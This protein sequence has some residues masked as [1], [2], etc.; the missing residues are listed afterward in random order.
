ML[1]HIISS[2]SDKHLVGIKNT[3]LRYGEN[4]AA[5][6][7]GEEY[8]TWLSMKERAL[9]HGYL[10]EIVSKHVYE[11]KEGVQRKFMDSVEHKKKYKNVLI[12]DKELRILQVCICDYGGGNKDMVF[13]HLYPERHSSQGFHTKNEDLISFFDE[14]F[15][16][17]FNTL[18]PRDKSKINN[19]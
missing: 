9:E 8:K 15:D 17:W 16:G 11:N 18:N 19:T 12:D 7:F 5:A 13:G 3:V 2:A 4:D 14:Y 1:R 6:D 10:H